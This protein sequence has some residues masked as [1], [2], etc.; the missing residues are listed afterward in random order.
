MLT[1]MI[2]HAFDHPVRDFAA[3]GD[4]G[5]AALGA[6]GLAVLEGG[7]EVRRLAVPAEALVPSAWGLI[8]AISPA[9]D[10]APSANERQ[11]VGRVYTLR[12]PWA[13]AVDLGTVPVDGWSATFD[14]RYWAT[15]EGDDV[16]LFELDAFGLAPRSTW[17]TFWPY[18]VEPIPEGLWLETSSLGSTHYEI[19]S[20]PD[21]RQL[22]AGDLPRC[23][24]RFP[25]ETYGHRALAPT[26]ARPLFVVNAAGLPATLEGG[27]T[28]I[29]PITTEHRVVTHDDRVI[30]TLPAPAQGLVA[31]RD[32]ALLWFPCEDGLEL[33]H[34]CLSTSRIAGRHVLAG[35]A[36]AGARIAGQDFWVWDDRGRLLLLR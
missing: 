32:R 25:P 35:A 7:A 11:R 29:H 27:V 26:L 21:L 9:I 31:E 1:R 19:L 24:I 34:V 10:P 3:V 12:S 15:F 4:R 5:I 30:T 22:R 16:H 36:K 33:L 2:E 6:A 8:L 23:P 28:R 18:H 17:R 20:I 13:E 14:G